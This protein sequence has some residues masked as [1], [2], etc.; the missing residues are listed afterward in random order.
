MLKPE[1]CVGALDPATLPASAFSETEEEVRIRKAQAAKLPLNAMISIDDF[2]VR[3][4]F[5]ANSVKCSVA[6]LD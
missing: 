4:L 6:N 5:S 2:E 3:N 1:Q